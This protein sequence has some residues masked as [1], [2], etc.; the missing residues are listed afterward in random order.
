M[1]KKLFSVLLVAALAVSLV[2]CGKKKG[3]D[4][5]STVN[6]AIKADEYQGTIENNA[7][8]YKKLFTLPE[9]KDMTAEVDLSTYTVKD[10]DVDDYI[11]SILEST[12][13][14][15]A[16]TTGTTKSGDVI[17]LDYS[18]KLDGVTFSGGTATDVTYTIGSGKFISDLDKGLAGL[19]VGVQTDIPCTFPADYSSSD[20]AGK[21][22]VFT[23]TVQSIQVTKVP[24]LTDTWVAENA[25]TL[26]LDS[27]I[28][29][30][31]AFKKYV[32][33]YLED[34]ALSEK[35]SE[36][37]DVIYNQIVDKIESPEYPK[38]ELEDLLKTLNENIDAEY[39]SYGTSYSSKQEYLTQAYGFETEDDF[40][41]Y[42]ENYAKQYLLQKMVIT[43]IGID[44]EITVT[45]DEI[46]K[47]GE[48]LATYYGYADY[49]EIISSYGEVMNSEIGYQVLYQK[50]LEHVADKVTI[51]DTSSTS[52]AS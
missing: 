36:I 52:S 40:N 46:N 31:D 32:K 8:V 16:Q 51:K 7:K 10:S 47:T 12:S 13:T 14:T 11:N 34:S 48:E 21:A 20:L 29:T 25:T 18:G 37:F 35:N 15:E 43:V 19:T 30:V 26:G 4:T 9:W 27:D 23:V 50:V 2:A 1:K 33:K 44:E 42:A 28:K 24:T 39:A 38:E 41:D 49:A 17:V 5:T 22:V 3:T 6:K 45:G